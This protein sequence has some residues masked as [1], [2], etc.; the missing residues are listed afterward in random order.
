MSAGILAALALSASLPAAAEP[1]DDPLAHF[2]WLRQLAGSCWATTLPDGKTTDRQCYEFRLGRFLF[3]TITIGAA[4]AP[5]A[6]PDT[7]HPAGF[8]GEGLLAW[9]AKANKIALWTWASDGSFGPAEATFEGELVRFPRPNK[10][11]PGAPPTSRTTWKRLDA[12]SFRVGQEQR[13]NGAWTEK[14]FVVYRR[15]P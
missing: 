2:G 10:A 13:E 5:A 15:A 11:D 6:G 12:D 9:D 4:T 7:R 14:W 3:G 8:R 1:A